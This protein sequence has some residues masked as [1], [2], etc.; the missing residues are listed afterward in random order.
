MRRKTA[1]S[2]RTATERSLQAASEARL[3]AWERSLRVNGYVDKEHLIV[4]AMLVI[5][6]WIPIIVGLFL[7]R[8]WS[9]GNGVFIGMG[10]LFLCIGL[11]FFWDACRRW[12][13]GEARVHLFADGAVLERTKGRLFVL[14]YAPTPADHVIWMKVDIDAREDAPPRPRVHFWI[15]LPDGSTVML[16]TEKEAEVQDISSLAE[17]WGLSAEPR[18]LDQEPG[19]HRLW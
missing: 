11:F 9:W 6:P 4:G 13:A 1:S 10:V 8:D 5:V 12:W 17:R 18:L 14:P 3:G 15:Q 7:F 19:L 2:A 16:D